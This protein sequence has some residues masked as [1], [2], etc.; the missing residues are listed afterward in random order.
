MI[1]RVPFT[2]VVRLKSVLIKAGPGDRTPTRVALVRER[3]RPWG[4]HRAADRGPPQYANEDGLDFDD[5]AAK[6]PTQ[7]FEMVQS[8]DVGDYQVKASKFSNV[9]SVTLFFPAAQGADTVNLYYVGFM[10]TWTEVRCA[11]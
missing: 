4:V 3:A 9:T 11:S 1:L 5:V 8:R 6:P 2:G 10:G 7:E